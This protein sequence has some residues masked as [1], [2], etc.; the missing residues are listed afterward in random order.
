LDNQTIEYRVFVYFAA[1]QSIDIRSSLTENSE[2]V[3]NEW[4]EL[5]AGNQYWKFK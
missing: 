2:F 1:R 4:F 5:A 3:S